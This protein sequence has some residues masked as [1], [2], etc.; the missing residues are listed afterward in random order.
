MVWRRGRTLG[1][2]VTGVRVVDIR[3]P[4]TAGLPLRKTVIRY[5]AMFI[6]T[7]PAFAIWIYRYVIAGGN[8]DAMFTADAMPWFIGAAI[9][10]FLWTIVLIVQIAGKSDPVYDRLAG[11]AALRTGNETPL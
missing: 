6:G 3:H 7:V 5:L 8:A 11:T 1:A 10:A 2:R 9:V 4:D